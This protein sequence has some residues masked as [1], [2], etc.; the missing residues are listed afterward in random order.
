M[1][2]APKVTSVGGVYAVSSEESYAAATDNTNG[3]IVE[4]TTDGFQTED[5]LGPFGSINTA[6]S[7]NANTKTGLL[8][9]GIGGLAT[10]DS[11]GTFT[12]PAEFSGFGQDAHTFGSSSFGAAGNFISA[13]KMPPVSADGVAVSR[14]NGATWDLYDSGLGSGFAARYAAFPSDDTWYLSTGSW[15]TS[16]SETSPKFANVSSAEMPSE[17][18]FSSKISVSTDDRHSMRTKFHFNGLHDGMD[19]TGSAYHGAIAKTTDG[20]LTWEPVLV[21]D[22]YYFNQ[23]DCISVSHCMAVGEGD[24]KTYVVTTTDGGK[25]WQTVHTAADGSTLMGCTMLSAT[26]AWVSGGNMDLE[27]R[28]LVG[29][30]WHTLDGGETWELEKLND[31]LSMGMSFSDG[32]GYSTATNERE[33]G[34]AIY[35]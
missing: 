15:P 19:R 25:N 9:F 14:D 23:I 16:S 32:V 20:G 7:F 4:H 34:V 22:K 3:P 1:S 8:A 2:N 10:F 27:E 12:H 11:E 6:V 5:N 17:Y 13:E 18:F 28:T 24:D 26:E 35:N 29:Y 31:A 21:T 30:F 33:A